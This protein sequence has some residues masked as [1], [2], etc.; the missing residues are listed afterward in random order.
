[1]TDEEILDR[2][3]RES[4]EREVQWQRQL[5]EIERMERIIWAFTAVLVAVTFFLLPFWRFALSVGGAATIWCVL[6]Y[7]LRGRKT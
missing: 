6:R 2:L 4:A 7:L 5:R 3:Y 1:M